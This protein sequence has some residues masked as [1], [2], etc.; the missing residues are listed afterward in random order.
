M[1]YNKTCK[2][3]DQSQKTKEKWGKI[4]VIHITDKGLISVMFKEFLD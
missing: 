3:H 4:F 2:H 1:A